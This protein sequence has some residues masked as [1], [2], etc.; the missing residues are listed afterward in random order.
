MI[1]K[2]PQSLS[3]EIHI[4]ECFIMNVKM[5]L[6]KCTKAKLA[7]HERYVKDLNHELLELTK[8]PDDT[9]ISGLSNADLLAELGL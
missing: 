5:G 2:T 4:H 1:T 7:K 8:S 6:A 3:Q 9:D